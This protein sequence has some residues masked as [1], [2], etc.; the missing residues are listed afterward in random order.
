MTKQELTTNIKALRNQIN[1]LEVRCQE[2]EDK[3]LKVLLAME[4][5]V[6]VLT[7][8]QQKEMMRLAGI[9]EQDND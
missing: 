2:R 7:S 5:F 8:V 6:E 1:K 3:L 9:E 4:P